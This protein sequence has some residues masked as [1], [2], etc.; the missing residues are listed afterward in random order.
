MRATA[1]GALPVRDLALF[2][3]PY[4]L[5]LLKG[6]VYVG[7]HYSRAQLDQMDNSQEAHARRGAHWTFNAEA[8]IKAIEVIREAS[9]KSSLSVI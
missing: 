7:Y 2:Q 8:F 3:T 5:W 1:S 6:Y 4:R 9:E